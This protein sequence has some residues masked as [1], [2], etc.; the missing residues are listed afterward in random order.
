MSAN[1]RGSGLAHG[2]QTIAVAQQVQ[3]GRDKPVA[4][5]RH[6]ASG[7]VLNDSLLGTPA[8][9]SKNR[10]ATTHAFSAGIGETL[11]S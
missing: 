8:L 5:N 10:N 11:D 4:V 2:C 3:C 7:D 9:S 1:M 6:T